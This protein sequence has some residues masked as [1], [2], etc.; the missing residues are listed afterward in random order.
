MRYTERES[1]GIDD[2]DRER[3]HVRV[4][5]EQRKR[6][7]FDE[8]AQEGDAPPVKI[9]GDVARQQCKQKLRQEL[10]EADQAQAQRTVGETVDLPADRDLKDFLAKRKQR[11]GD[12]VACERGIARQLDPHR[13]CVR[14]SAAGKKWTRPFVTHYFSVLTSTLT[15]G[16]ATATLP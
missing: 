12:P 4:G 6:A 16:V 11:L 13:R 7:E 9:V 15:S 2:V 1:G 5:G 14:T 10:R 8:L 3:V